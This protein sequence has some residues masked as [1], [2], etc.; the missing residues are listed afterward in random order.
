M[1]HVERPAGW[2]PVHVRVHHLRANRHDAGERLGRRDCGLRLPSG[3]GGVGDRLRATGRSR[4]SAARRS[5]RSTWTGRRNGASSGSRSSLAAR[6]WPPPAA[7]GTAR[8]PSPARSSRR[9]P[10]LR[11]DYEF[12]NIGGRKMSTSQGHG[13]A[14]HEIAEVLPP[15][16]A[17]P[18]LPAP[19]P[20]PGDRVRPGRDRCDPAPL[21]RSRTAWPPPS[22]GDEVRGELPP[23]HER[24]F[25]HEPGG[26]TRTTWRAGRG[27]L[28]ARRSRTSRS[29]C[30]CR[31]STS[32]PRVEAEKGRPSRARE[33]AILDGPRPRRPRLA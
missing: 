15:E 3:P 11:V 25:A 20:E 4:R 31:A 10:P 26:A 13:A 21:R 27:G 32:S 22:P 9:E 30:R 19:P 17:A 23:D 7:R 33:Q 24:L 16:A 28:P 8:T 18:P 5:C 12:L 2:V 29:C 14:A 6:T 1:S